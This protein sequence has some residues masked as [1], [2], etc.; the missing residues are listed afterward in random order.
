MGA[1]DSDSPGFTSLPQLIQTVSAVDPDDPRNGQ[2]FY[3]SLAPEA[4][5]NPNFTVRDNQGKPLAADASP[6]RGLDTVGRYTRTQ[7]Q[8]SPALSC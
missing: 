4:A 2:H 5:N 7:C 3:Y 8:R 1:F 6:Q